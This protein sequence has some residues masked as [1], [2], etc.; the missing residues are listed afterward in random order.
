M[1]YFK[2]IDMKKV[3]RVYEYSGSWVKQGS[4]PRVEQDYE[5]FYDK[6]KKEVPI[7]VVFHEN[8][9]VFTYS[10]RRRLFSYQHIK[11]IHYNKNEKGEYL[12]ITQ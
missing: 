6:E 5:A 2:D 12:W 9:L 10:S 1:L 4:S 11:T 8:S 3:M 7:K